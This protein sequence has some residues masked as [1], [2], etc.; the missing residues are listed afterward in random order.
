MQMEEPIESPKS[1]K[2]P[3]LSEEV[4]ELTLKSP[5]NNSEEQEQEEEVII[6]E[7][8]EE[9]E[10]TN[11][12]EQEVTNNKEQEQEVI[13]NLENSEDNPEFDKTKE[14]LK[15]IIQSAPAGQ[16]ENVK[17]ICTELF[18]NLP[19][20]IEQESKY[21]LIKDGYFDGDR[22][23][24]EDVCDYNNNNDDELEKELKGKLENYV[25]ELYPET[26]K[27]L[28]RKV[29]ENEWKIHI[30]GQKLKPKAFWSGHWHSTWTIE[31]KDETKFCFSIKG[32]VE[33]IVHYHEEGTV[34]L[35]CSKEIPSRVDFKTESF[36][37]AADKIYWKIKDSEDSIQLS[38]N[39]AYQQLSENIFKKLRRQLPVTRTKMDWAK[40]ANYNLSNE[41]KK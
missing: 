12:E 21:K 25:K 23:I 32:N 7:E 19:N 26:G 31:F 9:T 15:K 38:L 35:S 36:P 29:N 1:P 8:Q 41:L 30:L 14:L 2:T 33:L 5:L 27:F 20:F 13:I 39:E 18:E 11:N 28:L 10:I 3:K 37:Q 6:N 40:F 34:Q 22:L 17:N 24:T 4:S 16:T